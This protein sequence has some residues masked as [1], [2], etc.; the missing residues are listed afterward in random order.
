[1]R[2]DSY[3]L[4]GQAG[5]VLINNGETAFGKFRRMLILGTGQVVIGFYNIAGSTGTVVSQDIGLQSAGTIINA[6]FTT[7]NI[8]DVGAKA[9]CYYE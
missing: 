3:Q 9:I 1:M 8:T 6:V 4:Q 5:G 7:G 2:G